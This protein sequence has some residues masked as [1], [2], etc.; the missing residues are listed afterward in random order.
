MKIDFSTVLRGLNGKP[1]LEKTEGDKPKPLTLGAVVAGA[2]STAMQGMNQVMSLKRFNLAKLASKGGK[3][4]LAD[5]LVDELRRAVHQR[6]NGD[7]VLFGRV[8]E[9]VGEP[10]V[11]P[12]RPV[13]PP[14]PA[15]QRKAVR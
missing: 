14:S 4:D 5:D 9:I 7:P 2:A 3:Q 1:M 11:P 6:F 13:K 12:A 8:C 10:P 15:P